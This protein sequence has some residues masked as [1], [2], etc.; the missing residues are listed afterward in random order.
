MAEPYLDAASNPQERSKMMPGLDFSPKWFA[1]YTHSCQEKR[2]AQQ[3][4]TRN[5]EF[6]LPVHRTISHWKNGLRVPIE[7][8]LFPGY[9][10]V[11]AGRADRIRILEAPGVHSIVGV[12]REPISLPYE[13]MEA[14]RRGV[15]SLNVEPHPYLRTGEKVVIR[16]GPLEGM[17]GI[18]VRQKNNVRVILSIDLIMKSISV[19]VDG[20]DLEIVG[21]HSSTYEYVCP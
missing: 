11:K 19:E 21:Q 1:A 15:R 13:E 18:V 17:T 8:P 7:R 20:N 14:L 2:V 16:R 5:I 10:F 3:L 6:F 12:G 9:V 4:S